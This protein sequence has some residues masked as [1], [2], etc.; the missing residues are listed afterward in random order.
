[1]PR[2]NV[3]DAPARAGRIRPG[4]AHV[5]TFSS[6]SFALCLL[7]ALAARAGA[8]GG[9]GASPP[10]ASSAPAPSSPSPPARF[11]ILDG[12]RVALVGGA[13]FER[14][15]L[16]GWIETRLTL[17]HPG[18]PFKLRNF[19]WSGDTVRGESRAGFDTHVQGYERL[20]ARVAEFEPTLVVVCYG[21]NESFEGEAG[22]EPFR[23]DFDRVLDDLTK[24][25]ARLAL[26]SPPA[27][28]RLG[29]PLPDPAEAN[30]RLAMYSEA[31]ASEALERGATYLDLFTLSQQMPDHEPVEVRGP[32]THDGL[33][34]NDRGYWLVADD[35]ARAAGLLRMRFGVRAD[36]AGT[37]RLSGEDLMIGGG[38]GRRWSVEFESLPDP[39]EGGRPRFRARMHALPNLPPPDDGREDGATRAL[40]ERRFVATGLPPGMHALHVAGREVARASAK[41][42]AEGVDVREGPEFDQ[43]EA[44]RRAIVKKNELFFHRWRPQ[45]DTYL[46]LFRKHEQGQNAKE[47]PMFDPLVAALDDEIARLATP[48]FHDYEFV[49]VA[50]AP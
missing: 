39:A 11:E 2:R 50:P 44:L 1:M 6:R 30:A 7:V 17:L 20:V 48:A 23:R 42:W 34:L 19:A 33:H 25:G 37:P 13:F 15:R 16:H 8:E 14:E 32:R 12:D 47:I 41:E 38:A 3:H 5:P 4:P 36:F 22:L 27:L 24:G 21:L 10:A 35:L 40:S 46:F 43:V 18:V 31:I 26:V 29:P 45:N 9:A 28:E 49:P